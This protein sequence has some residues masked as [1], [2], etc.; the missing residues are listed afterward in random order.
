MFG[1]E[2]KGKKDQAAVAAPDIIY[3]N[4]PGHVK[5]TFRTKS[6]CSLEKWGHSGAETK[7]VGAVVQCL[8][9]LVLEPTLS[10]ASS[11]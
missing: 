8:W 4:F 1:N 7:M 9:S 10:E 6:P 11:P 5:Y 3:D 2:I